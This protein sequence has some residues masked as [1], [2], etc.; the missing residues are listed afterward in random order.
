MEMDLMRAC[1]ASVCQPTYSISLSSSS[2]VLTLSVKFVVVRERN[3]KSRGG[4]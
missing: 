2:G 1:Y 3:G 4:L